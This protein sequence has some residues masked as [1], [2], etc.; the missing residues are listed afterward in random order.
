[1]ELRLLKVYCKQKSKG[2]ARVSGG[3]KYSFF[4]I[5]GVLFSWNTP[6]WDLPFCLIT[7]ELPVDSLYEPLQIHEMN[8][9]NLYNQHIHKTQPTSSLCL[10]PELYTRWTH[11][12]LALNTV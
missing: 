7:N 5:F 8:K 6:F 10:Y 1:M 9:L 11:F 3:K 12:S 2:P 4:G